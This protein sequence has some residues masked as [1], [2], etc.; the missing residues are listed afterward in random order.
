MRKFSAE[1]VTTDLQTSC[2]L[3]ENIIN[4][5][6]AVT[7]TK[8]F[9]NTSKAKIEGYSDPQTLCLLGALSLG[10]SQ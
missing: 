6:K 3:L 9:T 7:F 2:S 8:P 1:S 5:S 4:I 10:R